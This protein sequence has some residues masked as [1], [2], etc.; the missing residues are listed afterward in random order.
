[1]K[2][3]SVFA[4]ES[5]NPGDDAKYYLLA[6]VFH[7][8]SEDVYEHIKRYEGTLAQRGLPDIPLHMNPL[9][10][11]NGAYKGMP[12]QERNR[13]LT[14]F[15]SFAWKCPISYEVL[16]YR[17]SHFRD[18]DGL[19]A[20]MKRDL[21]LLLFDRL[22]FLQGYDAVKI[23]YDDGQDMVTDTLHAAFEY[24]LNKQAV[25]YRDCSPSDFRLQQMADFICEIELAAIKYEANEVGGTEKIFFG[26]RRDFKK[27]YLR[28]LR[29]KQMRPSSFSMV[30]AGVGV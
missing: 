28:K 3:L 6:L 4:D 8:Q 1:M 17:K 26:N 25:L 21:V 22:E 15:S 10:R 13:L 14:C 7:D 20:R 30:N 9:M 11:A 23:Y 12:A 16:A 27:N 24:A 19:L 5:G 2:E 29:K 18:D